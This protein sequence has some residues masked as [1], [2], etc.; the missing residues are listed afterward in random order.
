MVVTNFYFPA[1]IQGNHN[2]TTPLFKL[3]I[4]KVVVSIILD[5]EISN[6]VFSVLYICAGPNLISNQ[7]LTHYMILR[8]ESNATDNFRSANNTQMYVRGLVTLYFQV[9]RHVTPVQF[10]VIYDLIT[11]VLLVT[12]YI[13]RHLRMIIP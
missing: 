9:G 11:D 2:D 3:N 10:G 13:Y 6:P 1:D 4:H 5:Q 8:V 7:F 12:D